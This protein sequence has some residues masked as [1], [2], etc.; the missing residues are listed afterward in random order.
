MWSWQFPKQCRDKS[1][2]NVD[3]PSISLPSSYSLAITFSGWAA[4]SP[5]LFGYIPSHHPL[6]VCGGDNII[7]IGGGGQ[8]GAWNRQD[9]SPSL[10]TTIIKNVK[11][12]NY[13][14]ICFDLEI[15]TAE[16]SDFAT[17]FSKVKKENLK[18]M[19]TVS[20]FGQATWG[21][22]NLP[23]LTQSFMTDPNV[24]IF[25]PQLYT[26]NC[27]E[28]WDGKSYLPSQSVMTTLQSMK[29]KLIPSVNA[30]ETDSAVK[31]LFPSSGG[32]IQFCNTY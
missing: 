22:S 17:L 25:S 15:G 4:S 8:S 7:S 29:G 13:T 9:F 28:I 18:V 23:A 24:D 32:T 20:W 31:K 6:V 12:R 2:N 5:Q 16:P 10:W 3:F 11:Q 19:V 26:N 1:G 30:V 27:N 21:F 14:G